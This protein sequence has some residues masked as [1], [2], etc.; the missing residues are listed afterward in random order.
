[1]RCNRLRSELGDERES[2]THL[3]VELFFVEVLVVEVLFRGIGKMIGEVRLSRPDADGGGPHHRRRVE[4]WGRSN[5]VRLRRQFLL[6]RWRRFSAHHVEDSVE[7]TLDVFVTR[8]CRWSDRRLRGFG[9]NLFFER[10]LVTRRRV[11][12]LR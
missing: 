9:P 2:W 3:G 4:N 1:L 10:G 8:G 6:A 11:E 7:C 5:S 12:A